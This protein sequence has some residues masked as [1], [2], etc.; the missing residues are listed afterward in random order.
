MGKPADKGANRK[1]TKVVKA[2]RYR[3]GVAPAPERESSPEDEDSQAD[4][5][6]ETD[7]RP[8]APSI[9]A[10]TIA[11]KNVDLNE[12]FQQSKQAEEERARIEESQRIAAAP[13]DHSDDYTTA[14]SSEEEESES[15]EEKPRV[16]LK[17]TF[18]PKSL[19]LPN[20]VVDVNSH[21]I[22]SSNN[23]EDTHLLIDQQLKREVEESSDD[24]GGDILDTDDLDPAAERATWKLRELQRIKREKDFFIQREKDIEEAERRKNLTEEERLA[25]DMQWVDAQKEKPKEK[26]RFMQKYWHKGAFYQDDEILNRNYLETVQDDAL[27]KENLPKPMQLKDLSKLGKAGQTRYTHL[28]DQDTTERDSAWFDRNSSIN[29]RTLN[30]MGGMKDDRGSKRRRS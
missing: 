3:P 24:E 6:Q 1:L 30:K 10:P 14:E 25:E 13:L 23:K 28:V 22:V 8:S 19:P 17:P 2:P 16:L 27:H 20:T 21:A 18:I 7:Q 4:E 5:Q 12:R 29:K 26:M 15:E 11:L 9:S